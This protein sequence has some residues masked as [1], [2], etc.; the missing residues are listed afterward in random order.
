MEARVLESVNRLDSLDAFLG[1]IDLS[2]SKAFGSV[3]RI[4]IVQGHPY[5]LKLIP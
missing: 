4:S 5:S 1:N 2:D 3:S